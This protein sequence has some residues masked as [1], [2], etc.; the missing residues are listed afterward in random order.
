MDCIRTDSNLR[1][2]ERFCTLIGIWTVSASN[3]ARYRIWTGFCIVYNILY[4][5]ALWIEQIISLNVN[6]LYLNL[7]EVTMFTKMLN[8]LNNRKRIVGLLH[9]MHHEEIFQVD[10]ANE[11]EAAIVVKQMGHFSKF[12]NFYFRMTTITVCIGTFNGF[13]STPR[14]M[15]FHAWYP[16]GMNDVSVPWKF[17]AVF[18]YQTLV[19]A[20]ALINVCWDN[21]FMYLVTNVQLQFELLNH[22]LVQGFQEVTADNEQKLKKMFH[23]F[24]AIMSLNDEIQ[25]I[26]E[27]TMFLQFNLS[28]VILCT[29]VILLIDVSA[30]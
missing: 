5:L 28:T 29:T 25:D 6:D 20:H 18:F 21:L 13:G 22:R 3:E 1:F 10:P 19:I 2:I 24:S 23:N 7:S 11:E 30:L 27:T 26:F 17:W 4:V 9:R 8:I 14:E 12:A 15:A 16:F